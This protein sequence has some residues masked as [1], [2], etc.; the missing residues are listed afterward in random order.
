MR[1]LANSSNDSEQLQLEPL[2]KRVLLST[3]QIIAAGAENTETM[4][5]QVDG[6]TVQTWNNVGGNADQGQFGSSIQENTGVKISSLRKYDIRQESIKK[7]RLDCLG[8]SIVK[9]VLFEN[10]S[11]DQL[12]ILCFNHEV[13]YSCFIKTQINLN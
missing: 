6:G 7:P 11:L 13:V 3:V 2:E 5:L 12:L 9:Y 1:N 10:N 8:F 4:Q